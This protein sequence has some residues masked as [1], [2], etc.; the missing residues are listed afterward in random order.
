M[1]INASLHTLPSELYP[2]AHRQ[3]RQTSL[4]DN[5]KSPQRLAQG[6]IITQAAN[7]ARMHHKASIPALN[8]S[9]ANDIIL[10]PNTG[11]NRPPTYLGT[12]R[13]IHHICRRSPIYNH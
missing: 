9:F 11:Q 10:Q 4:P 5:C 6:I 7:K 1:F 12:T 2:L 8:S 13:Y 3:P